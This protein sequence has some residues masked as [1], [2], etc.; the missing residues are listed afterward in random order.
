MLS[1]TIKGEKVVSNE[2]LSTLAK[3]NVKPISR[4]V[5]F[6]KYGTTKP[7][8]E[9]PTEVHNI[10]NYNINADRSFGA[11]RLTLTGSNKDGLFSYG[12]VS[13]PYNTLD[14]SLLNPESVPLNLQNGTHDGTEYA[15]TSLTLKDSVS[16]GSWTSDVIDGG[17]NLHSW[18][19]L[20]W[21]TMPTTLD[22]NGMLLST[23]I[24]VLV[25]YGSALNTQHDSWTPWQKIKVISGGLSS[26]VE[27]FFIYSKQRYIQVQLR[28]FPA[29][30]TSGIP[31]ITSVTLKK[32][33]R[34]TSYEPLLN[35][36]LYYYG[37]RIAVEEGV[38]LD[39]GEIEWFNK[40][41][42]FI[43]EV[44]PY[45]T[46]QGLG[47]RCT[48]LDAMRMCLNDIIEKPDPDVE[49][50]KIFE[51]K[52][53]KVTSL[54]LVKVDPPGIDFIEDGKAPLDVPVGPDDDGFVY[55]I[56]YQPY[57][58]KNNGP[59]RGFEHS[60]GPK[61]DSRGDH[62]YI[63]WVKRPDVKIYVDGVH[64]RDGFDIDYEKGVVYFTEKPKKKDGEDNPTVRA[65]FEWYDMSDNRLEDV[66]GEIIALAIKKA[67]YTKPVR[68]RNNIHHYDLWE[69]PDHSFKIILEHSR[70][71]VTIPPTGFYIDDNKTFFDALIDIL[72]FVQP[73]Y[74]LR[75][76]AEGYFV[77]E[78]MPQINPRNP[79]D[80]S[81]LIYSL[82]LIGSMEVPV[83]EKD[84]FT[85]VIARG[86]LQSTKNIALGI[87]PIDVRG[88]SSSVETYSAP[89][90]DGHDPK[91]ITSGDL[92]TNTGWVFLN[93]E[94]DL[95]IDMFTIEL[96]EPENIG[97]INI[98]IGDGAGQPK[99]GMGNKWG[100]VNL[101]GFGVAV[102]VSPNK[103]DWYTLTENDFTGSSGEWIRIDKN[104]FLPD[105]K[106]LKVKYVR[107]IATAAPHFER[108]SSGILFGLFG[109]NY[110]EGYC[111]AIRQVQIFP[112]EEIRQDV[113]IEDLKES[114]IKSID[115][116]L[117]INVRNELSARISAGLDGIQSRVG[118]KTTILPVDHSLQTPE[119][120]KARGLDYLYETVRNLHTS[121][122]EVIY[123][124]HVRVGHTVRLQN[125]FLLD[126]GVYEDL[127]YVDAV[128]SSMQGTIPSTR[129]SLVNWV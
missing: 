15:G 91:D 6:R 30:Q 9:I 19:S 60:T 70:P 112:D 55:S 98:L 126:G 61:S 102:E 99:K 18:H 94:P 86:T 53:T 78:H 17:Q 12:N 62:K 87:T 43:D 54:E 95:P 118:T 26:T 67:G 45:H 7:Y 47:L 100:P 69:S 40:F 25:R 63:P 11:A 72:K 50:D 27:N 8:I 52:K 103:T 38:V 127:Y 123:A 5:I 75:A 58:F 23:T 21:N 89:S 128:D 1:P 66:L 81:E 84:I 32:N 31:M 37:N 24:E 97:G 41:N 48:A 2:V 36:P 28:L 85:K 71:R 79:D 105:I 90:V 120:V 68:T 111:W 64:K 59:I 82:S 4:V 13:S 93:S 14:V 73:D 124:P 29:H 56:P 22:V 76:T 101:N 74:L 119:M 44:S 96:K 51:A 39:N 35:H 42:G 129:L 117:P 65:S 10:L 57:E 77:G 114:L 110:E 34:N 107:F 104:N 125:P 121:E 88:R 113:D 49:G 46:T 80:P 20:S 115:P 92:K 122:V 108:G 16:Y 106:S 116:S 33:M 109:K 3:G 83:S